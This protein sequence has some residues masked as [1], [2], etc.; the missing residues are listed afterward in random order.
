MSP[1]TDVPTTRH[2][3]KNRR[4]QAAE[5]TPST[6]P[7]A[8]TPAPQPPAATPI[9]TAP[10][11]AGD[12]TRDTA[13]DPVT[14]PGSTMPDPIATGPADETE[15]AAPAPAEAP[16]DEPIPA[17]IEA[18]TA[19]APGL[20]LRTSPEWHLARRAAQAATADI[21]ADI[22]AMGTEAWIDRQIDPDSID[23]GECERLIRGNFPWALITSAQARAEGGPPDY[24]SS[25]ETYNAIHYRV[26]TT[27]RVLFESVVELLG[28]H[29]YV[30]IHGKAEQFAG[31]YDQ[32]LRRNALGT[33]DDLLLAALTHPALLVELDNQY[34]HKDQPNENLGRE[35]LELYTVGRAAYSEADVLSSARI[36]TGHGVDWERRVYVYEPRDHWTGPVSVLG[37]SDANASGEGGPALLARYVKHLAAHPATAKRLAQKFAVRF[38]ADSPAEATISDLADAYLSSGHSL[39]ALTRATLLHPEFTASVGRKWRRPLEFVM[40]AARAARPSRI[41]PPGKHSGDDRYS[42]GMYGW[43]IEQSAHAPRSWPTVEGYPDQASHWMS[44][45]ILQSQWNAAQVCVNGDVGET[46]GNDWRAILGIDPGA[47][48]MESARLI[49]SRLTG[50]EWSEA[51][52]AQIAST[53]ASGLEQAYVPGQTV[54][55]DRARERLDQA[56]R[57]TF[58]SPY[59][60]LR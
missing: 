46:G 22:R 25:A 49:T 20:T 56:V 4:D 12:D 3:R 44:T 35:L 17:G 19:L 27:R 43:L 18:E 45:S 8:T 24:E 11:T 59:G 53:L 29:L 15:I 21:A 2:R 60:F 36:L 42:P 30:P 9:A 10:A 7:V 55:E 5:A 33:F 16:A 50:Y 26:R 13:S 38:I 1:N 54:S 48:A 52:L 57:L 40:T 34:S 37:F 41:D 51:H 39:A 14:A 31:E 28:D 32:L 23:D 47:D 6:P 58:A